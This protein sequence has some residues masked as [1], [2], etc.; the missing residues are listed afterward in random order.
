MAK[1]LVRTNFTSFESDLNGEK[2]HTEYPFE[3]SLF[4]L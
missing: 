4:Y 1:V 2:Y 3:T